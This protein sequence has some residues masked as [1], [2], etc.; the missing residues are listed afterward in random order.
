MNS[1]PLEAPRWDRCQW[2]LT[3][4]L[5]FFIQ[6]AVIWILGERRGS[7]PASVP[8]PTT[9]YWA[10][11]PWATRQIA[12]LPAMRDPTIFA[13]PS[14]NGFSGTA[15]LKFTSPPCQASD[16]T[17]PPQW[18]A[19]QPERL[20]ELFARTFAASS[21]ASLSIAEKSVPE[22]IGSEPR[23]TSEPLVAESELRLAGGLAQRG[24]SLPLPL[25][26]WPYTEV[27]SNT[28]V[29][30][31]VDETGF[32]ISA[33]VL[34]SCRLKAADDYALQAAKEARFEPLER[35][36][37]PASGVDSTG[38]GKLVFQ[39]RTTAP[40]PPGAAAAKGAP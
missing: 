21:Y 9:I 6:V 12:S 22:L 8:F 36:R 20:G 14:L 25:P 27:L 23:T 5:L 15:W 13:L 16:W 35:D 28:T 39:W 18:L 17:E 4:G 40:P 11:D 38:C 3:G 10:V 30:V 29:Q 33:T 37:R 24:V 7:P 32:V 34:E 31:L 26:S 2:L 1:A 19:P